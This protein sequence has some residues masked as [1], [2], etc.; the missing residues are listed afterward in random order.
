M[1]V[2]ACGLTFIIMIQTIILLKHTSSS[3]LPPSSK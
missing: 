3:T 2:G 1:K